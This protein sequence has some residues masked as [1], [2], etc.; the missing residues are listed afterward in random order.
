[1]SISY[2]CTEQSRDSKTARGS[3]NENC[4]S[5]SGAPEEGSHARTFNCGM[6]YRA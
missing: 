6:F 5:S 1:M 3:L 4:A 2:F